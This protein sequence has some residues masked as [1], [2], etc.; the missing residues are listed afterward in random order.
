MSYGQPH[1]YKVK[2]DELTKERDGLVEMI[3]RII[4]ELDVPLDF[5][6][7]E[8]MQRRIQDVVKALKYSRTGERHD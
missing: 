7:P 4:Q 2:I 1:C 6:D 8:F 5:T 3:E